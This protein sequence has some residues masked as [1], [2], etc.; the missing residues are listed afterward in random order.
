MI[1]VYDLKHVV[2]FG[3]YY[4]IWPWL[5]LK[6]V[7]IDWFS[8]SIKDVLFRNLTMWTKWGGSVGTSCAKWDCAKDCPI[9]RFIYGGKSNQLITSSNGCGLL[10]GLTRVKE[11]GYDF[12]GCYRRVSKWWWHSIILPLYKTTT[13]WWHHS[14]E[15]ETRWT[16][17]FHHFLYSTTV[18]LCDAHV[19]PHGH[20]RERQDLM[21]RFCHR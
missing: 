2:F 20:K 21:S 10:C 4:L 18:M 19:L 12:P 15:I 13:W 5:S 8:S 17:F 3:L 16:S 9:A 7:V 6:C 1:V 14:I 11:N